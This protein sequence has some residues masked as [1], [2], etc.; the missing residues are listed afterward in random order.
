MLPLTE[1]ALQY[2]SPEPLSIS[3]IWNLN[4]RR[5]T[6]RREY[7]ALMKQ[8]GVDVILCPTY[9]GAGA[10][11]GQA[12]YWN[13]TAIWNILDQPGVVFPSG[14][15]VDKELDVFETDYKPMNEQDEREW[16]A[17]KYRFD[18]TF[19]FGFCLRVLW[20]INAFIRRPRTLRWRA[21]RS[22]VGWET[23]PRREL[24]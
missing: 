23:L 2:S 20:L 8:R 15:T 16:K 4:V 13:Y 3:E 12:Y 7:H 11:Q 24:A 22:A 6:Y 10:L 18:G 17:C 5:E 1:W 9:V 19:F 21:C 14:L